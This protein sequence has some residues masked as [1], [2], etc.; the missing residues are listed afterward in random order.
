MNIKIFFVY[1]S[2]TGLIGFLEIVGEQYQ[3]P[4]SFGTALACNTILKI[5]KFPQLL[6]SIFKILLLIFNTNQK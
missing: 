4:I 3:L 6:S 5:K 1:Q 2:I